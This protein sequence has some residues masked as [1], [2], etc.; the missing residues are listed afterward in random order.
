MLFWGAII[1]AHVSE[2]IYVAYMY[3]QVYMYMNLG[4]RDNVRDIHSLLVDSEST[5]N[6]RND[7]VNIL[8]RTNLWHTPLMIRLDTH[9]HRGGREGGREGV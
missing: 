3:I 8:S 7:R 5:Y 2:S 9:T 4:V 1:N 6:F